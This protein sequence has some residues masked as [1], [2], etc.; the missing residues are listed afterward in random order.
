MEDNGGDSRRSLCSCPPC[1]RRQA[2]VVLELVGQRMELARSRCCLAKWNSRFRRHNFFAVLT[3]ITIP[4]RDLESN[5]CFRG[6]SIFTKQSCFVSNVD[7]P[8]TI[9]I[10]SWYYENT[11]KSEDCYWCQKASATAS[12]GP[13]FVLEFGGEC[14]L[15]AIR[16][17][18]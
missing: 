13:R 16:S 7:T 17:L 15:K 6:L 4:H 9:N 3:E 2:H 5:T 12:G 10:Y 1:G 11:G 14:H 18:G 8:H